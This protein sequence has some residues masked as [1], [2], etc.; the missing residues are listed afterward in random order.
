M[1]AQQSIPH[2]TEEDV[3]GYIDTGERL[4]REGGYDDGER[5]ALLPTIINLLAQKT[6]IMQQPGSG[7]VDLGL[8]AGKVH[9]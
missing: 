5:I 9:A 6:I 3:K 2:H 8:I 4:L 7:V 1:S